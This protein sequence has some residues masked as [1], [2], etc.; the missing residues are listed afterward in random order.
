MNEDN[1]NSFSLISFE[2]NNDAHRSAL[3]ELLHDE[4]I[5]SRFQG[6]LPNLM[7]YQNEF[8]NRGFL[9]GLDDNIVGYID[10]SDIDKYNKYVY[11]RAAIIEEYR[12]K[13]YGKKMLTEIT[14]LLFQQDVSS[15]RLVID[16][17]NIASRKIAIACGYENI[18]NEY[19]EKKNPYLTLEG[20]FA[21][22]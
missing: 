4:D 22:K 12:N 1:D 17:D 7:R 14:E 8:Y 5:S 3:Y 9:L 6:L 13:N 15:V 2:K 21:L 18:M 16:E 10:I 20:G 11:L 19:F